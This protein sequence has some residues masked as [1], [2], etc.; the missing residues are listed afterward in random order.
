MAADY[1]FT[2]LKMDL[3]SDDEKHNIERLYFPY[4]SC[5]VLKFNLCE[6]H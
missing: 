4:R 6:K 3:E 5:L 2:L 1:Y